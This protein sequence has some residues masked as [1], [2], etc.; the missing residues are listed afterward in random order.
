VTK[1]PKFL[2]TIQCHVAPFRESNSFFMYC[3]ISFSIW[4][5]SMASVATRHGQ[6]RW[7]G[8]ESADLH[9]PTSTA[10]CCISS[11]WSR[12]RSRTGPGV[13]ETIPYP[14]ILSVLYRYQ[15]SFNLGVFFRVHSTYHRASSRFSFRWPFWR[16]LSNQNG[17]KLFGDKAL[18]REECKK[19]EQL[20]FRW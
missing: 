11:L 6:E 15:V 8:G 1:L 5:F 10:S 16:I 18:V 19:L 12:V 13:M 2:P 4:N 14:R 20:Q 17:R 9:V 3:A 7:S